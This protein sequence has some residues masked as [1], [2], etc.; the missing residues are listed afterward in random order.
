MQKLHVCGPT[1]SVLTEQAEDL[2]TS[3]IYPNYASNY[4]VA[5]HNVNL[6]GNTVLPYVY[7]KEIYVFSKNPSSSELNYFPYRDLANTDYPYCQNYQRKSCKA[8]F[9]PC[10]AVTGTSPSYDLK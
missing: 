8:D 4:Q 3:Y 9:D 10:V 7:K 1:S 5:G 6:V 2:T